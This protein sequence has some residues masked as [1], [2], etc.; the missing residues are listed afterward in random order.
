MMVR[1][2]PNLNNVKKDQI[3]SMFFALK[4]FALFFSI[5]PIL[6]YFSTKFNLDFTNTNVYTLGIT[7]V[8][9]ILMLFL[10]FIFKRNE[11]KKALQILEMVIF[12]YSF[13]YCYLCQWSKYQ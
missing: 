9:C 11:H 1:H 10:M 12:Y 5:I 2:L 8:I 6:Q 7:F 13:Y 4:I 3:R